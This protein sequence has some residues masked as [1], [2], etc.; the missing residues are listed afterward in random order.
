MLIKTYEFPLDGNNSSN[1]TA[2]KNIIEANS[3]NF[4]DFLLTDFGGDSRYSVIEGSFEVTNISD[5]FFEYS[6]EVNFYAG[7]ADMNDTSTITGTMEYEIQNNS[8]VIELD[9]TVWDVR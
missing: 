5:G 2:L 8:I 6:T 1:L 9:E 7:C 4:E 3:D